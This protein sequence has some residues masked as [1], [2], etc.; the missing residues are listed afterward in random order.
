MIANEDFISI[1]CLYSK[2][3]SEWQQL[4][5]K[6]LE[7]LADM[8][9]RYFQHIEYVA[10]EDY[11]NWYIEQE[12]IMEEVDVVLMLLSVHFLTA[13]YTETVAFKNLFKLHHKER[14]LVVP[15]L[16]KAVDLAD[17]IVRKEQIK[18]LP[19]NEIPLASDAWDHP[20]SAFQRVMEALKDK[21]FTKKVE[22]RQLA[23]AWKLATNMNR[24]SYY[25]NFLE[26]YP[27]SIHSDE[28]RR[29][30]DELQ[31]AELWRIA[32]KNDRVADYLDYL[33]HAPL[34]LHAQQ[35]KESILAIEN[36]VEKVWE[37]TLT[38]RAISFYLYYKTFPESKKRE[39]EVNEALYDLL[40]TP[41]D[42]A[43][44][45]DGVEAIL[46]DDDVEMEEVG[47]YE[48]ETKYLT[49]AAYQQLNADELLSLL[50]HL[51]YMV[52]LERYVQKIARLV[53]A[54]ISKWQLYAYGLLI[55][56]L[57][58]LAAAFIYQDLW[59][60][61]NW[62]VKFVLPIGLLTISALI[63]LYLI[64]EIKKDADYCVK[65]KQW[66]RDETVGMKIAY[67]TYDTFEKRKTVERLLKIEQQVEAIN[68][69]RLADYFF[70]EAV[71]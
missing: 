2:Q 59:Y 62:F 8:P 46:E 39:A 61:F 36:D 43:G 1:L 68:R 13:D 67:L 70:L 4:L 15:I 55:F 10:V 53:E 57:F 27:Y 35:A 5:D 47:K 17:S 26:R 20:D 33:N 45:P 16:A 31:E 11:L 60:N 29:R 3:D 66:V 9:E 19:F 7:R 64:P 48:T 54:E 42:E 52:K 44:Q 30:K 6:H 40:Q 28:A 25:E 37:D 23:E 51:E 58:Y 69:K 63:L 41:I 65:R 49:Y 71:P 12:S 32:T 24:L 14:L 21:L 34:Q 18:V 50:L 22:K 56:V 38:N